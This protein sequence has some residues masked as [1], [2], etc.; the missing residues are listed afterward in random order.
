MEI[1]NAIASALTKM[2]LEYLFMEVGGVM[3]LIF[4]YMGIRK[5]IKSQMRILDKMDKHNEDVEKKISHHHDTTIEK[6]M[7]NHNEIDPSH[8]YSKLNR[9]EDNV[10]SYQ[11]ALMNH[12]HE[13]VRS[14]HEVH[15]KVIEIDAR[16]KSVKN[17]SSDKKDD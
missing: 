3:I 14:L 10:D 2:G 7:D 17:C 12:Q 15:N 16:L 4:V 1:I 5:I 9:F 6:L 11:E 8:L 13:E